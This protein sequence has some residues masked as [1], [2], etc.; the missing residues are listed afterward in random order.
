M[1]HPIPDPELQ[2]WVKFEALDRLYKRVSGRDSLLTIL[3]P[4]LMVVVMW[5]KVDHVV[6]GGWLVLFVAA[7][8]VKLAVAHA[9][10][11]LPHEAR[12]NQVWG[13]RMTAAEAA[14]G[15]LWSAAVFLF[16]VP[17]SVEYQVFLFTTAVMLSTGSV[18]RALY[19]PPSVYVYALPI[20]AALI[21]RLLLDGTFSYSIL[22]FLLLWSAIFVVQFSRMLNRTMLS[23]MRLRRRSANLA[24]QLR[25][26]TQEAER[27]TQAKSRFLAAASHDLRQPLYALNLFVDALRETT[28]K[29]ERERIVH[30]IARSL[31][32]LKKLF[33]GLLDVSRLDA[34]VVTPEPYPFDVTA[35]LGDLVEEFSAVADRKNVHLRLHARPAVVDTD[36]VL[37]ARILRNLIS[38][39]VRYTETGGVLLSVRRRREHILLQVWDTGRGI[40]EQHHEEIFHEF[41]QLDNAHRDRTE[42]LGLGLAI[43]Q[44]LCWLLGIE[45]RLR[46]R[47]GH[48]TVF[49]LWLKTGDGRSVDQPPAV[50]PGYGN[51]SGQ[52]ALIID[53]ETDILDGMNALLGKW[54]M[55]VVT[56]QTLPEAL[57]K[58]APPNKPP[59]LI[60]AD[61]RLADG[62]NGVDA[63]NTIRSRFGSDIPGILITADT[64]ADRISLA[65]DC[66][67]LVLHKPVRAP[68][69][70]TTVQQILSKDLG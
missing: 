65:R 1:S 53:D 15:A 60:V 31:D 42:G 49:N 58:I 63:M 61:L 25:G 48:G 12:S 41:V 50:K 8:G 40:P 69:L 44:R 64:T 47:P 68:R 26:K 55:D 20:L 66:G 30:R 27:A 52:R 37:L 24:R 39:A 33:D 59:T 22:A 51:L 23:E 19:W 57:D 70:R 34:N 5:P 56:A 11:R 67:Y 46:S 4:A 17:Q 13:H 62:Q 36:A 10:I 54:G 38:N 16:Y 3:V 28:T 32:E 35:L 45:M 7:I 2:Q 14:Y 6:L 29:N 18:Y 43:V 21:V 9:Y